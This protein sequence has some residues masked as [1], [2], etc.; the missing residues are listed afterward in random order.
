MKCLDIPKNF[1]E[2]QMMTFTRGDS[3]A[4]TKL[5]DSFL[6]KDAIQ[7]IL[8]ELQIIDE[9]I[10]RYLIHVIRGC[11]EQEYFQS[12]PNLMEVFKVFLVAANTE[13]AKEACETLRNVLEIE[14]N[15]RKIVEE[16]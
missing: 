5:P 4:S 14:V 11:M 6:R 7:N 2:I 8:R 3:V 13:K 9:S 10:I 16:Y 12:S 1:N 15:Q